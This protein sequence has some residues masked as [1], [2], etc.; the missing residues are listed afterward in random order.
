M[1]PPSDILAKKYKQCAS[2]LFLQETIFSNAGLDNI[3]LQV[4]YSFAIS[5]APLS[6]DLWDCTDVNVDSDLRQL[7]KVEPEG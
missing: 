4:F 5:S 6:C 2:S 1:F 3:Y 7:T